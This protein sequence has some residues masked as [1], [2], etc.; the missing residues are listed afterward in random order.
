MIMGM[1]SSQTTSDSYMVTEYIASREMVRQ[2]EQRLPLREMYS[3]SRADF[4]TRLD[5]TASLESLVAYW[6]KRVD[7]YFDSSKQTIVVTVQGFTPDDAERI[8][9]EIVEIARLLVNDLSAQSRRD[10]VQFAATELARAELRARAAKQDLLEFR[11]EHTDLDPTATAEATLGIASELEAERSRLTS[12]LASLEGYLAEDAPSVQMLK[13]RIAALNREV[14][15]I[16]T[17]IGQP[18]SEDV[19]GTD[20]NP[21]GGDSAAF[22][23]LIG[24]YQD[25][26]LNQEFAEKS[27]TA[28]LASLDRARS[29]VERTQSYL[30]VYVHPRPAESAIYPNR[31]LNVFIVLVLAS[32]FWAIGA[33]GFMTV[34]DHVG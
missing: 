21:A 16:K 19:A 3:S 30:A 32:V 12:Q 34:R 18:G 4:L 31:A 22:A 20:G 27:Y 5:P 29:E 8:T 26:I 23:S 28:A 17:H 15:R 10:A 14:A 6:N 2:L 33:L 13:S 9:R 25:L 11:I 24:E 7:A 1:P